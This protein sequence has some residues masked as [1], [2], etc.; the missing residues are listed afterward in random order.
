MSYFINMIDYGKYIY[1]KTV[2]KG[3]EYIIAENDKTEPEKETALVVYDESNKIKQEN[4]E[5]EK[6]KKLR[7]LRLFEIFAFMIFLFLLLGTASITYFDFKEAKQAV[8]KEAEGEH[9][10]AV[11]LISC[12]DFETAKLYGL[13]L[14]KK[15]GAGFLI[16]NDS[17]YDVIC[18]LYPT[19]EDAEKVMNALQKENPSVGL[20]LVNV[21]YLKKSFPSNLS[22]SL[23]IYKMCFGQLYD[24]SNKLDKGE[25]T[26]SDAI[27]F[28]KILKT[29]VNSVSESVKYTALNEEYKDE[30]IKILS[31]IS[32]AEGCVSNITEAVNEADLLAEI[33]YYNIQIVCGFSSLIKKL[34]EEADE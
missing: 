14:R 9:F 23:E 16:K 21:P 27:Y 3:K 10:Y 15:G 26:F 29:E 13:E 31:G 4:N 6:K 20:V 33:R 25:I 34:N 2:K 24:I 11:K 32:M 19:K 8:S 28:T 17:S 12:V 22:K 1:R 30:Y 7:K 18:A 5:K